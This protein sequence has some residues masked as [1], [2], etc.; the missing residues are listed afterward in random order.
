MQDDKDIWE[1]FRSGDESSLQIIFD[2]YYAPLFNYGH[3]FSADDHLI[4]DALQDL[5][6]KLW[7]NRDSI[8]DTN[9]VKNYLY[10]SFRRVLLR[11][12]E[13]Q[14]RK[15]S[16][17]VLDEWSEPGGEMAYDQ[18]M[19][20]RERLE[21]IRGNLLAA[22]EKMTPRQREIIH[23]RYYEEM[24]YEEIAALMQLSVSSTY[25]LLYKAIDTL[26]QY[27]SKTDLLILLTAVSLKKI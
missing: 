9:S 3:R 23:L 7:K 19:I 13:V 17:A 1:A 26:R 20:S 12:L 11:I 4:E 24:E 21:E 15:Y 16:F 8:K 10:K 5:F 6:V 2:K 27:L 25:K 14:Q 18:T 22:L